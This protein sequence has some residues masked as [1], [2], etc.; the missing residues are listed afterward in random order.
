V[1][2]WIL[3]IYVSIFFT[4]HLKFA[5]IVRHTHTHTHTHKSVLSVLI[6]FRCYLIAYKNCMESEINFFYF[7]K[8]ILKL[9]KTWRI[10]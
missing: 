1:K 5:F 2:F 6:K 7:Y 4:C 8:L 3:M 9:L 10:R